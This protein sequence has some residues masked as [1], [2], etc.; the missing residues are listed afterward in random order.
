[1][2]KVKVKTMQEE[3]I[4]G[5]VDRK[6][7]TKTKFKKYGANSQDRKDEASTEIEFQCKKC[8][9]RHGLRECPTFGKK[10]NCYGKQ[11]F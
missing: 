5:K 4:V 8:N 10:C 7:P 1:M 3:K 9:R 6:L 11:S 2:L